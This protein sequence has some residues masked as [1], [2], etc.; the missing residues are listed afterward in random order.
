MIFTNNIPCKNAKTKMPKSTL[1]IK[2]VIYSISSIHSYFPLLRTWKAR[3][4]DL[5]QV[6]TSESIGNAVISFGKPS[7]TEQ[8][9]CA[10]T[11]C[12][13]A[14]LLLYSLLHNVPLQE[15]QLFLRRSLLFPNIFD[16]L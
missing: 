13:T 11:F 3:H 16:L 12:S 15:D 5:I 9:H 2:N 7:H 6:L 10:H 4:D 14:S 8:N 1:V